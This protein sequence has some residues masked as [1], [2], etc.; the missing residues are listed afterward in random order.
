MLFKSF[1]CCLRVVVRQGR[2]NVQVLF[3]G[4]GK[5]FIRKLPIH[6]NQANFIL[7]YSVSLG[8][9][10]V[11]EGINN[12]SMKSQIDLKRLI[13][14][15]I[16]SIPLFDAG[17][18][19]TCPFR[20]VLHHLRIRCKGELS[21]RCLLNNDSELESLVDQSYIK[22]ADMNATLSHHGYQSVGL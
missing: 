21:Y 5:P 14:Q 2:D 16:V 4:N 12:S 8:H 9:E 15:C 13:Q 1:F 6:S 11:L 7:K 22:V 10:G 3:H 19:R 20:K 18:N 17:E